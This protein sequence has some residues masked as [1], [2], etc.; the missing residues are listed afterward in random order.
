MKK[1]QKLT[2]EYQKVLDYL[3]TGFDIGKR[4]EALWI[5][6]N[7][8]KDMLGNIVKPLTS[9]GHSSGQISDSTGELAVKLEEKERRIDQ[10]LIELEDKR[11]ELLSFI[12]EET[13]DAMDALI[14]QLRFVECKKWEQ[15]EEDTFF[16]EKYPS[17][18]CHRAILR[19]AHRNMNCPPKSTF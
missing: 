16:S 19:I 7:R 18:R 4:S 11:D 9:E 3:R 15:I 13:E 12:V 10:Q 2:E 8:L 5:E 1:N 6:K 17:R 14:L